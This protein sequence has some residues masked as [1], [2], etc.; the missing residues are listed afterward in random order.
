MPPIVQPLIWT[1]W[2]AY[3]YFL[4]LG[5]EL[6]GE[7]VQAITPATL[8]SLLDSSLCF[9]FVTPLLDLAGALPPSLRAALAPAVHPVDLALFNGAVAWA[10]MWLGLLATDSRSPPRLRPRLAPLW[11][12]QLLLTNAFL[13]PWLALRAGSDG[14]EVDAAAPLPP[15]L[16]ALA[17]SRGL[18]VACGAVGATAVLWAL[19]ASP[20]GADF[21]GVGGRGAHFLSLVATDRV[22]LAFCV[23]L[24]LFSLAQAWLVGDEWDVLVLRGAP[25]ASLPPRWLRLLP[26]FGHAAWLALRPP[27]KQLAGGGGW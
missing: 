12:G 21:G 2:A 3:I 27:P 22:A 23:D 6:P 13:L 17:A 1:V 11:L 18:G 16:A 15:P 7:P 10:A 25:A 19:F 5:S 8:R 14:G 9:F 24:A 20:G 4:F 26:F